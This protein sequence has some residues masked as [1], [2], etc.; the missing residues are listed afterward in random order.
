MN[1]RAFSRLPPM[2]QIPRVVDPDADV[3][4]QYFVSQGAPVVLVG[5]RVF[6]G[7]PK[8]LEEI[9]AGGGAAIEVSVRGGD[10]LHPSKRVRERMTLGEYVDTIIRPRAAATEADG[11]TASLPPYS[12]N[13]PLSKSAF[14][15]LGFRYPEPFR[16]KS[17]EFPR[18]WIGPQGSMTPLHYDSRDN[19]ICQY[20]GTKRLLLFPPSQIKWLYARGLAPSWSGVPDPRHP[21]LDAFPLF[22][23]ARSVEVTLVAGELLYL[24]ARWSHFV[25]NQDASVMVN[26]W[27]EHSLAQ[28]VEIAARDFTGRVRGRLKRVGRRIGVGA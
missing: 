25:V 26:F 6:H 15:A 1:R 9:L 22:A 17:F 27:P 19:L 20:V 7:A 8:T 12:G 4:H 28:Q 2:S 21:D 18:L 16:G 23:R 13:T 11:G 24:P 14:A 3:F 5:S 10:Y